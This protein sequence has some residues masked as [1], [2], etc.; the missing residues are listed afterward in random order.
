[1]R[2]PVFG[3]PTRSDINRSVQPQERL[4][5]SDLGIKGLYDPYSENKGADQLHSSLF[6]HMQKAVCSQ[7][8]SFFREGV[9]RIVAICRVVFP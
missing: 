1:M 6:S 9:G 5:S 8:G 3:F 2:K 7:R 4:E